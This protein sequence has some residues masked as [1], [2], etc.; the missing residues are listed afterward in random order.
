MVCIII[1]K[2]YYHNI[3]KKQKCMIKGIPLFK[4]KWKN[5]E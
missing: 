4:E 3:L 2:S 1:K 5:G